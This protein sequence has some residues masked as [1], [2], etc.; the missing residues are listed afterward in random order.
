MLA[1][2]LHCSRAA[3]LPTDHMMHTVQ[4]TMQDCK[5]SKQA[6]NDSM[7]NMTDPAR[8]SGDQAPGL[9]ADLVDSRT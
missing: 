9:K 5:S 8:Q 4:L 7:P 3:A 6:G 1:V 2:W